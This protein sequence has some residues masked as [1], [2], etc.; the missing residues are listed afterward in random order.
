MWLNRFPLFLQL[1]ALMRYPQKAVGRLGS[2]DVCVNPQFER[3]VAQFGHALVQQQQ[4]P[5]QLRVAEYIPG[6]RAAFVATAH[7]HHGVETPRGGLV[8]PR[9]R[10]P[11]SLE[12]VRG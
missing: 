11:K 7:M 2:L 3:F 8:E 4:H 1:L 5:R 6:A 10:G 12:S 9:G